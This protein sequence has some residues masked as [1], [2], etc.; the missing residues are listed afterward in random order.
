MRAE[1]AGHGVKKRGKPVTNAV[2]NQIT[3]LR[4]VLWPGRGAVRA[5][6]RARY[7]A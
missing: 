1:T 5:A 7:G 6:R 4:A 2:H 3:K